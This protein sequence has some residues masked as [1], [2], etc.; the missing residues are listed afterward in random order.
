MLCSECRACWTV[1][2]K[3]TEKKERIIS[4]SKFFQPKIDD[5]VKSLEIKCSVIPAKAG[6]QSFRS[7]TNH[8]DSGFHRSDDFLRSRQD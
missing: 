6:I 5:L 4:G 2:L 1:G 7:V 8:L 3:F